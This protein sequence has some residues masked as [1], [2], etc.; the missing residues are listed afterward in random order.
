MVEVV[1][2]GTVEVVTVKFALV[3]PA[4]I[5]TLPGATLAA[6]VLLLVSDTNAPPAGA[7]LSSV[8]VP[9]ELTT[10][11]SATVGLRLI[12]TRFAVTDVP[13]TGLRFR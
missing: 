7:G 4:G 9:V 11:P 12:A 8:A 3:D 1:S 10:P 2:A 13:P 6:A 5:V